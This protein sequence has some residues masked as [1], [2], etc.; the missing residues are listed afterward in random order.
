MLA[1]LV[2]CS[3]SDLVEIHGAVSYAGAPVENGTISFLPTDGMTPTAAGLVAN[4]TYALKVAP[5][6]KTVRIEGFK[7]VGR[8]HSEP[9][10]PKSPIIDV[11]EQILP[12]RY[13]VQ[14]ELSRDV[15]AAG[16]SLDFTLD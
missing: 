16:G 3:K 11:Y 1:V 13:N 4:G 6:K 15:Q 5:G 9:N 12:E 8:R 7:T 2:G 10:N 14:S